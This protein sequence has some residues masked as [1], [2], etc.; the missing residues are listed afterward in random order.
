MGTK[1]QRYLSLAVRVDILATWP[2]D[3]P[4][5]GNMLRALGNLDLACL[6]SLGTRSSSGSR[7]EQD[8][9]LKQ[10]QPIATTGRVPRIIVPDRRT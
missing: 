4:V 7:L 9:F 8:L 3:R 2:R 6:T 1:V 5:I 10:V